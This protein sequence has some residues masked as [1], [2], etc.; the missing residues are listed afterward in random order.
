MTKTK[1]KTKSKATYPSLILL[2]I[3]C[4]YEVHSGVPP[5][6]YFITELCDVEEEAK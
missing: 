1:T 5:H 3:H 6:A 2:D 4:C